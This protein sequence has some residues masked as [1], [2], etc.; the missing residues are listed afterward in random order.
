LSRRSVRKYAPGQIADGELAILLTCGLY[1]PSGGGRQ[2]PRFIV[3]QDEARM[4]KLNRVIQRL[5]LERQGEAETMPMLQKGIRRAQTPGY[6]FAHGAPTLISAVAPR[7]YENAMADCAC[8]LENM[9]LAAESLGLGACW[10]NQPHWL[11][12]EPEVRYIFEEIGL[13]SEEDI[14]GS[15]GVGRAAE[16]EEKRTADPRKEGRIVVDAKI[17]TKK[18]QGCNS[19]VNGS[20]Y[21]KPSI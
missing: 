16:N 9:L 4:Q 11:T 21:E 2:M 1:A 19:Q 6:R 15:I 10:S 14:F 20:S 18:N 3:I 17:K 13:N 12:K 7:G 8:A 5:L